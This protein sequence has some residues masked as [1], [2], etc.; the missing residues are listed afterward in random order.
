MVD[1]IEQQDNIV[2]L[3]TH[4]AEYVGLVDSYV[5]IENVLDHQSS[6]VS[7]WFQLG[8]ARRN[9]VQAKTEAQHAQAHLV[10][11]L[12]TQNERQNKLY[13]RSTANPLTR[14][15]IDDL[16]I[17]LDLMAEES[18]ALT[19]NVGDANAAVANAAQD[20]DAKADCH[21]HHRL[22]AERLS[23]LLTDLSE[24]KRRRNQRSEEINL[25][26][27]LSRRHAIM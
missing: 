11:H 1:D 9:L 13:R 12:E 4:C 27:D 20:V 5:R 6:D 10:I 16:I 15:Q 23:Q 19:R 14:H 24:T 18:D 17:T 26:D 8:A 21:R 2:M 22:A 3:P 25:D 7:M